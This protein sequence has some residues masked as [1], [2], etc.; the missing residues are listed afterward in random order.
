MIVRI[1]S[2]FGTVDA[3][4]K[5]AHTGVDL[6]MP[7]GTTL[8]ALGEGVVNRVFYRSGWWEGPLVQ[9]KGW[10]GEKFTEITVDGITDYL[11]D[12]AIAFP[13]IAVVSGCVYAL[14]NMFSKGAATGVPVNN[15]VNVQ[16]VLIYYIWVGYLQERECQQ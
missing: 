4:H 9:L 3:V 7:E 15:L 5:S 10:L 16:L 13:V 6:A 1:T 11:A 2:K 14:I 12:F 8:R